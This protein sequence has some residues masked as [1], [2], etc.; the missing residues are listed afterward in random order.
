MDPQGWYGKHQAAIPGAKRHGGAGNNIVRKKG[1]KCIAGIE[2][3]AQFAVEIRRIPEP[4]PQRVEILIDQVGIRKQRAGIGAL[5]QRILGHLQPVAEPRIILV[6]EDND[7][8]GAHADGPFEVLCGAQIPA[9]HHQ[10]HRKRSMGGKLL[11][12]GWRPIGIWGAI[13]RGHHL[14]G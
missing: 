10:P 5:G 2:L 13:V 11:G 6:G 14:V 8:A 12:D 1:F 3:A 4:V 9:V 7:V